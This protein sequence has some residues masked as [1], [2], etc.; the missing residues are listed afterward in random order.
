MARRMAVHFCPALTVISR[1]TSLTNRSNSGVPGA[2][3]G[4]RIEA[5]RLSRSAMK[6]TLSRAMTGW[7][8]SFIAVAAEPVKETT[9][10]RVR[11]SSRSPV[12]PPMNCKRAGRQHV[13]LDHDPERGF[14]EIAGRRGRLDDRRHAGEQRR[15]ELLEHPP[16]R[17]VEGVDVDGDALE[18]GVDVL[19]DEAAALRQRLHLAVDQDPLVGQLAPALGGEGEERAGAALDVDPAVGA[20]RAGVVAELV[21]FLLARHDRVGERLEHPGALVE[22]QAP[23]RRPADLAGMVEHRREVEAAAAGLGD[24]LAGDGAAHSAGEP[25]PP[26]QRSWA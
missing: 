19:A 10:C 16:D 7:V 24:H 20:G 15:P 23:Q 14:G 2:A 1:A 8:W 17:E 12:E 25:S 4:P 21:Q 11:W 22:G 5:L 9:S 3:S 18:R 13:G 6:R 26:F